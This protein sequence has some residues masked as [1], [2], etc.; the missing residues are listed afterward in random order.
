MPKK[1]VLISLG[2]IIIIAPIIESK[3]SHNNVETNFI[4]S[5]GSNRVAALGSFSEDDSSA[6]FDEDFE[7]ATN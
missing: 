4:P 7:D 3:L 1:V 2:I 5:V 6:D